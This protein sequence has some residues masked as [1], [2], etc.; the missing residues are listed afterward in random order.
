MPGGLGSFLLLQPFL[1]AQGAVVQAQLPP[2]P[3]LPHP[4]VVQP[5]PPAAPLVV[6]AA[7]AYQPSLAQPSLA[8]GYVQAQQPAPTIVQ[9]A[10]ARAPAELPP[11]AAVAAGSEIGRAH[12]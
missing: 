8:Q 2:Q 11:R 7:Q 10:E 6:Q 12:V 1:F 4:V 5:A 3:D 9:A